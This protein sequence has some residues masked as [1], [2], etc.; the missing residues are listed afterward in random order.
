MCV[1]FI[2]EVGKRYGYSTDD[3]DN[4]YTSNRCVDVISLLY[5][6]DLQAQY[7]AYNYDVIHERTMRLRRYGDRLKS[8]LHS[9]N[10]AHA[11]EPSPHLRNALH[12]CSQNGRSSPC[13]SRL[14]TRL[15]LNRLA[16]SSSEDRA[17]VAP[18]GGSS[19]GSPLQPPPSRI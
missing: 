16:S 18:T 19:K 15:S 6:K 9:S 12:S 3:D 10:S 7:A 13:S 17:S 11:K 2:F 8:N 5:M 14:R 1:K 4:P